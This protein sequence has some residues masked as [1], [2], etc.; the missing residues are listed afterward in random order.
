MSGNPCLILE[1]SEA[2]DW[3]TLFS[4]KPLSVVT[5]P[6]PVCIPVERRPAMLQPDR[7]TAEQE[8]LRLAQL[9][10]EKRFAILEV[11]GEARSA[12]VPSHVTVSGQVWLTRKVATL[13]DV[14]DSQI[15]F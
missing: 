10:P 14:D 7:A 12:E 6:E 2:L 13:V 11:V 4:R 3:T 5:R 8:A 9:M 1:W 15:P